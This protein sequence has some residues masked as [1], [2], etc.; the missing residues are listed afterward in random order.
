M[1]D[2]TA[3]ALYLEAV[4]VRDLP[5]VARSFL[6]ECLTIEPGHTDALALLRELDMPSGR[7]AGPAP[8]SVTT[9]PTVEMEIP[10]DVERAPGTVVTVAVDMATVHDAIAQ[11]PTP[12]QPL[13][14]PVTPPV[15][16]SPT[17][18]V[19]TH[20]DLAHL[21]KTIAT[22]TERGDWLQLVELAEGDF[23]DAAGRAAAR[24]AAMEARTHLARAA[25]ARGLSNARREKDRA[26]LEE[27][28]DQL[29]DYIALFRRR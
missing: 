12:T 26:Q 13:T 25:F 18:A 20:P 11:A 27:I 7:G 28:L 19:A 29:D 16:G 6:A 8:L 22:L 1:D 21:R 2:R 15:G 10:R 3:Q 5:S 17:R 23:A 14:G 9:P 4:R 24:V